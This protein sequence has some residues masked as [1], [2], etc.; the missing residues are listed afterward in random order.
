MPFTID[1]AFL[2]AILNAPPMT[3]EQFAEFCA[4]HPDLFFEMTAEGELIVMPPTFSLT[5]IRNRGIISQLDRWAAEDGRGVVGESSGGFVLANGARRS[6]DASWVAKEEIRKLDERSLNGYWHLC[7]A[8]VIELRSH[9]DRLRVLRAKMTEY[10]SN[11]AKLGWLMDAEART[12]EVYRLGRE[13][14]VLVGVNSIAGEG[15]VEGFVLNLERIWNPL[16]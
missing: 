9:S 10:I 3:D 11:G 14:E 4:E 5:S 15:P 16:A 7:P 13:A 2:P 6:P 8:F 12:V 1:E